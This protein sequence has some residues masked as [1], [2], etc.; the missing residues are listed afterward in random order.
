MATL[1]PK[2]KKKKG[3]GGVARG[4]QGGRGSVGGRGR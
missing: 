1:P 3:I 2:K 4:R